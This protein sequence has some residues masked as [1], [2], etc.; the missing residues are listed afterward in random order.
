MKQTLVLLLLCIGLSQI[1]FAQHKKK[2]DIAS[3]C[4]ASTPDDY[5]KLIEKYKLV[6][7]KN[8]KDENALNQLGMSYFSL[9]DHKN[10]I[11][12]F[13]RLIELNP[14]YPGAYSNRAICRL[15]LK[16]K[17]GMCADLKGAIAIGDGNQKIMDG[18]SISEYVAER[19][20]K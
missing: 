1:G 6:I 3:T 19:C 7:E 10:S 9:L 2:A 11:I 20:D 14:H 8:P 13:S 5:R 18:K 12:Y 17:E 16:D 15:M 4:N